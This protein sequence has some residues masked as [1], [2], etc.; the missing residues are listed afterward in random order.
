MKKILL[1]I[2]LMFVISGCGAKKESNTLT[3]FALNDFHG[4]IYD[5]N[6]GISK[7]GNYIIEEKNKRPDRTVVVA[8]GDMFQGTAF[9]NLTE[10]EIVVDLMNEIG[11]DAMTI[12]NHEFDWG[13]DK[14]IEL[15][16]RAN[17][18]FLSANIFTK[19]DSKLVNWADPYTV[20]EKG[21][22]KIGIIGLIGSKLTDSISPSIVEPYEFQ[23]ELPII[24][25]YAKILRNE[26]DCT[27]VI[28]S[29]HDDTTSI[30][31]N[32]A[33][34]TGDEQIDAVFNGHTHNNY[35][36]EILGADG[37]MMPY[38]QSSSSGKFIGKITL[39]LNE[40]SKVV[41]GSSYNV[42]VS[43]TLSSE[44]VKLNAIIDEYYEEFGPIIDEVIGTS[45]KRISNVDAQRWAADVLKY[46]TDADVAIINTGGIRAD[47][48]PILDG[49]AITFGKVWE[50]MPFDNV[51]KVAD[52]TVENLATVANAG[53]QVSSN[54]SLR[55]G[56]LTIGEDTLDPNT[57]IRVATID[58]LFDN[59][60]YDLNKGT[61]VV[62]NNEILRDYLIDY[63]REIT[64]KG[65]LFTA[66]RIYG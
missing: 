17:F 13:I 44:N 4:R 19:E 65:E 6:G 46:Y 20:V 57:V 66:N 25:E 58:Y 56:Y 45:G 39:E 28:L 24:K 33:D 21:G 26:L 63:V 18:P 52:M 32:I 30:N 62:D 41:N 48:F 16:E 60:K 55:G 9:S 22:L 49:Q 54:A 14:L 8:S 64:A 42:R 37:I 36:G 10:G 2:L 47:A 53:V 1:I 29:V 23:Q 38:V 5:D 35:H 59:P 34:L 27:I 40:N 7:I 43:S 51:V 3:I 31:Q 11:F 12:G 50:I 61:N 15:K